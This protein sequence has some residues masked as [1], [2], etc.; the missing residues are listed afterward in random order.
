MI[1]VFTDGSSRKADNTG[2]FGVVIFKDNIIIYAHQEQFSNVTN[3]QMELQAIIHACEYVDKFFPTE[4]IIIYSDS[5]YCVNSVNEWM[6]TWAKKNWINS[7]KE[8][9]KNIDLIK[10]LYK[11]FST[12][13]Y[14][15]Q[16]KWNKG[17]DGECGN[18]L[19][20]A[21][22]TH[23]SIKFTKIIEDNNIKLDLRKNN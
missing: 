21:L 20:D 8:T 14:H 17:H 16:L 22:A 19:A 12:D 7:K 23:N 18:E 9:V 3:N 5:S 10:T 4:E 15:C 13:F 1:E 11:Y 6:Y 2:G